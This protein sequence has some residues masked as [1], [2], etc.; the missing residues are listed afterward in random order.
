MFTPQVGDIWYRYEDQ[1]YAPPVDEFDNI[2]GSSTLK[3]N[4]L[5]F[6][7]TK[8]TPKG[9]KLRRWFGDFSGSDEVLVLNSH[10]K[11][12]ACPT[13]ESALESFLARKT[14]QKSIYSARLRDVDKAL[15]V[16][17]YIKATGKFDQTQVSEVSLPLYLYG[18]RW[19]C[20]DSE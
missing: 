4:L 9:V 5:E 14:R 1:S 2:V 13:K 8:L 19:L 20:H 3:V 11:K 10:N 18:V 6:R 17:N 16:A 12:H 7:V 15:T